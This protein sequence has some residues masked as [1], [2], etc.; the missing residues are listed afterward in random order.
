MKELFDLGKSDTKFVI[1]F[2]RN[3]TGCRYSEMKLFCSLLQKTGSV[4][5]GGNILNC[6]ADFDDN[7]SDVT[8]IYSTFNGA[9]EI[10]NF[11]K[12]KDL[13]YENNKEHVSV[14]HIANLFLRI[15]KIK[16]KLEYSVSS[17]IGAES[18]I[19]VM[20]VKD[21][22]DIISAVTNF[23][24]SF[25]QVLFDGVSVKATYPDH[26]KSRSGHL[27]KDYIKLLQNFDS[28]IINRIMKYRDR[29]FSV[30]IDTPASNTIVSYDEYYKLFIDDISSDEFIA[31][32]MYSRLI[33]SCVIEGYIDSDLENVGCVDIY[34]KYFTLVDSTDELFELLRKLSMKKCI[35]PFWVKN[36]YENKLSSEIIKA[37]ALK[38]CDL[39]NLVIHKPTTLTKISRINYARELIKQKFPFT[40]EIIEYNKENGSTVYEYDDLL[41]WIH[42]KYDLIRDANEDDSLKEHKKYIY[43]ADKNLCI[44]NEE[45]ERF[46][47]EEQL[48]REINRDRNIKWL[49]IVEPISTTPIKADFEMG[50]SCTDLHEEALYDIKAYLRGEAV[51]G[52]KTTGERDENLDLPAV[53]PAEARERLVFFAKAD[54]DSPFEDLKPY[55]FNLRSLA[56]DV[57]HQIFLECEGPTMKNIEEHLDYPVIKLNLG[58]PV[59]VPLGELLYAIY[60]TNKQSFIIFPQKEVIVDEG[61]LIE[62]ERKFQYTA[63]LST[64]YGND[65]VS[66]AHCGDNSDKPI[67]TIREC[68]GREGDP[69]WPVT[70]DLMLTEYEYDEDLY[71]LSQKY[72]VLDQKID[73]ITRKKFEKAD[74]MSELIM[75]LE[76]EKIQPKPHIFSNDDFQISIISRITMDVG[77]KILECR[78]TLSYIGN[79]E[80]FIEYI[81]SLKSECNIKINRLA[82]VHIQF[83]ATEIQTYKYIYDIESIP[84]KSVEYKEGYNG[85][86]I[87][88]YNSFTRYSLDK[89][90]FPFI[91][92]IKG[93]SYGMLMC[94]ICEAL[95]LEFITPSSKIIT[96]ASGNIKGVDKIESMIGIVKNFEKIGFTQMFPEYYDY[97]MER[98][99]EDSGYIAMVGEVKNITDLC[100]FKTVSPELFKLL[101]IMLC[102]DICN[103]DR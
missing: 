58:W 61:E 12:D 76:L 18:K 9:R 79:D 4:V 69:C 60:K 63:S 80:S 52:Y 64:L 39:L 29:G 11:F 26:I 14:T 23:D 42:Q 73:R 13:L 43:L 24:L 66:S 50:K 38:V 17:Y 54:S 78:A 16:V 6:L 25:S 85:D 7:L 8:Y 28:N 35:L 83:Y 33:I 45:E 96:E 31:N 2:V 10:Y 5:S 99:E 84:Q 47:L 34:L 75:Q 30:S 41:R 32:Y 48:S 86:I 94:C 49:N 65:Y 72:Y 22:E 87:N 62:K 15:T 20:I 92:Q 3:F 91:L 82:Y 59:Y 70:E 19:C 81:E 46:Q 93:I 51:E 44:L 40:K 88:F 27:E 37:M 56:K 90:K 102:K 74:S 53:S 98:M 95:K 57:S 55:C 100:T 67:Y 89:E 101:P 68:E 103:I 21:R 71:F 1:S 77:R 97:V 36:E